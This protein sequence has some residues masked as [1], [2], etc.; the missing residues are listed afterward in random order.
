M[1]YLFGL[2]IWATALFLPAPICGAGFSPV[3]ATKFD[4]EYVWYVGEERVRVLGF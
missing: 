3:Q 2:E 1:Q 4:D